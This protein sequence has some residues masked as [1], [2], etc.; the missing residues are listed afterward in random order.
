MNNGS[1]HR[2]QQGWG[3]QGPMG[4]PTGPMMGQ[5]IG[6]GRMVA[7]MNPA[8]PARGPAVSRAMV[9]MQMMGNGEE[10]GKKTIKIHEY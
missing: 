2:M 9:N 4:G 6:P 8:L 5:G 1:I 7:N 10:P 3:H